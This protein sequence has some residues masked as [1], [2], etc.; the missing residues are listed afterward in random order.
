VTDSDARL[1]ERA[2]S[3]DPA[4]RDAAWSEAFRRLRDP[5]LFLCRNLLGDAAEAED[6]VQEVFVAVYDGLARFRGDARLST[7]VYRIAIRVALR[8][9]CRRRRNKTEP[10][11]VEPAARHAPD[12]I[13][14]RELRD[15]LGQAMAALSVEHR[16]V[17]TLFSVE[18]L[19][20]AEIAKVLGIPVGTVWSRLHLARTRLRALLSR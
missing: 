9:R 5:V 18:G 11:L 12:P 13:E 16:V 1:I 2:R 19:P 20:H 4:E 14:A 8:H 15:Q 3:V 7:W 17:L 10:L 6:A